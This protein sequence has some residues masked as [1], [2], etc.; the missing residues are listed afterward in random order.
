MIDSRLP[1][2]QDDWDR[3]WHDKADITEQNPAQRYRRQIA[4]KLLRSHRC[5]GAARILDIGCGQGDLARDLRRLFPQSEITGL[6]FSAT[7]I[8]VASRKVPGA[9]FVQRNLIEP[10]DPGPLAGWAQFAV[11]AEVLEHLDDPALLLKNASE[12]LAPGC[13]LIVTVPG[14]PQ[15]EFDRHIGHRQHF[16]PAQLRALLTS[17]GFDVEL[18]T[19]AGFPF[20]NL[21]RLVVISRGK[22][23]IAD[24]QSGSSLLATAVMA[25]FRPLF[26]LNV[27]GSPW[28][29]QIVAAARWPGRRGA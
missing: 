16:T 11:C 21:Y 13:L 27:M 4:C 28:G 29:W 10:G 12:Y 9:R 14:G 8:Q 17:S 25:L 7:G 18:A 1:V 2:A 23:L 24:T 20:F 15:S 26:S 3:H 5:L 6:D 22:R 19:T